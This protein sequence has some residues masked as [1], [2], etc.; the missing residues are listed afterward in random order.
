[1]LS[2]YSYAEGEIYYRG[3]LDFTLPLPNRYDYVTRVIDGDTIELRK[4]GRVR[5]LGIDTPESRIN[6]KLERDAKRTGKDINAI[7]KMGKK[8]TEVTRSLVVGKKVRVEFDVE[9][10][11]KYGR[12]LAYIY[13]PDGK[14]LNAELIREGY[15]QVYT[16]PPNVKYVD[17]FLE[18]QRKAR[19]EK[20]GFW[21]EER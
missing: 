10:K 15:A 2:Q 9:K 18:L 19:E 3:K 8:A 16:F 11:D 12:W 6:P 4:I 20:K 21:K 1:M 5:L 7:I 17:R 13:L 14:M